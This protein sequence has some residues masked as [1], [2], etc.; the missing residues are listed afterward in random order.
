MRIKRAIIT[1]VLSFAVIMLITPLARVR[2]EA[3]NIA[4]TANM[5]VRA[6]SI[7]PGAQSLIVV[8]ANPVVVAPGQPEVEP[9]ST[10]GIINALCEVTLNIV[11]CSF[12]PTAA[13]ITCDTNGDGVA[14]LLI[15][16]KNVTIVSPILVQATLP[17]LG[18]QLPGTAFPLACCGGRA[19]ITVSRT[20]SA[21]DDNIFGPFTQSQTCP[22]ELGVRAPVVISASP[23]SGDCS[24]KQN[25]LIPGTCFVLP[26]GT[27][28]VT[29][30]FAVDRD[31]PAHVVQ[32]SRF[33]IL[34][35]NLIDA[36]FEFGGANAGR[37]FLIHVSGPNGTSRNL[38][39]LPPGTPAGCPLGNEQG[40]QVSFTCRSATNPGTGD[41]PPV[42]T[43][44]VV[45]S[46]LDSDSSGAFSLTLF[47]SSEH[48]IPDTATITVGGISP[49]KIRFRDPIPDTNPARFTRVI[50]KGRICPGL[51]GAVVIT[52]PGIG[53]MPAFNCSQSCTN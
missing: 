5:V 22:I 36:L 17:T 51:P 15:P 27:P 34:N 26:D 24:V 45:G 21:G 10:V 50:L 19:T 44:V 46:R 32:A 8:P 29:S 16:L 42:Q 52:V 2:S 33:E 35:P 47:I 14:E 53:Q 48:A 25:L 18:P 31:N 6:A 23:S 39:T 3:G 49:K 4:N 7:E 13:T 1:T 43:P 41:A 28:N 40:V 30:V 9:R 11:G 20:V 37:T 12:G 38:T